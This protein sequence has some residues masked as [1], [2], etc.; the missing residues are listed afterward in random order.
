MKVEIKKVNWLWCVF[1]GVLAAAVC[2]YGAMFLVAWLR[3][4]GALI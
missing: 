3:S 2:D 4:Q 1:Y